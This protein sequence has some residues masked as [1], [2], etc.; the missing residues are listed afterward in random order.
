MRSRPPSSFRLVPLAE[1][2]PLPA[3]YRDRN[4]NAE[5]G[6]LDTGRRRLG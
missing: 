6:S 2:L 4:V 1:G 5:R 3:F